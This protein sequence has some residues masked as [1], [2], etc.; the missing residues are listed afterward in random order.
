[1]ATTQKTMSEQTKAAL[2]QAAIDSIYELGYEK[3]TGVEIARRAGVTRGALHHHYPRGRVDVFID[4]IMQLFETMDRRY[5]DAPIS[6]EDWF[7]SRLAY[8]DTLHTQDRLSLRESWA[9]LNILMFGPLDD[10]EL[11]ELRRAYAQRYT[12]SLSLRD[13]LVEATEAQQGSIRPLYAFMNV[14][15]TGYLLQQLRMPE[16]GQADEAMTFARDLLAVWKKQLDEAE[17]SA[18]TDR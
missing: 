6:Y 2:R 9:T 15:F 17:D 12:Q 16:L 1:M 18:G 14:L 5:N 4:I 3:T 8:F 7:A 10:D 11:G 13:Q